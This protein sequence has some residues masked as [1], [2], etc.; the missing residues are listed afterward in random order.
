MITFNNIVAK[1]QE[2]CD[3][4]FFIKTFSYGSPSDVDL[5]KFEQYP[6][7][8]LVY[9]GGDYN[10][11]R[12]KTYNLE[13]Y[14]LTL[15][16]AEADKNA[17]QKESISDAE[18][19]AEDIL[20]DI[21]NGGDIFQFGYHY[22]L[23]SA[24][25]TPLEEERSNALAG[26]LLDLTIAVPYSYDSCNA[27][28]TGVEPEGSTPQAYRARGLLRVREIDGSPDV[29]SVATINVPNGS[30]TD[31]GDGEITLNFGVDPITALASVSY[32][33]A[34]PQSTFPIAGSTG[35]GP[36]SDISGP[37]LEDVTIV[38]AGGIVATYVQVPI[39]SILFSNV[40]QGRTF[41][42]TATFDFIVAGPID[43]YNV[44]VRQAKSSGPLANTSA[45]L[46]MTSGAI[47]SNNVQQ[48][49]LTITSDSF[50]SYTFSFYAQSYYGDFGLSMRNLSITCEA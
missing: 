40:P 22:D 4:H 9:T 36:L 28:L 41:T 38:N 25:V 8:H 7:M 24:S 13:I 33:G 31:D 16:P 23:T 26:C 45:D 20:A 18:Q 6:L 35:F 15:P 2:F 14:I 1:F 43:L 21:E 44:F 30:L 48:V 12:T 37:A 10:T 46:L 42:I 17:H 11:E 5:D 19:V 34:L 32:S 49:T 39:T 47:T 50:T 29:L 3:N 27:P